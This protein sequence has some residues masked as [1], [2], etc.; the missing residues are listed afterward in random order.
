MSSGNGRTTTI[1]VALVEDEAFVREA[2]AAMLDR[3]PG[4]VTVGTAVSGEEAVELAVRT[5]PDVMMVDIRIPGMAPLIDGIEVIRALGRCAPTVRCLV[6]TTLGTPGELRRAMAAGARGFL[7]KD[8]RPTQVLAAVQDVATGGY[9][10]SPALAAAVLRSG[11]SPLT[12][13]ELDVLR[14][15]RSHGSVRSIATQLHLAEGTVRN[16][17]STAIGKMGASSRGE[18]ART[19]EEQGWL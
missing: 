1:R 14:L 6:F 7:V 12:A 16:Y 15:S 19:A 3:M 9:A 17:L 5:V 8:T 2:F 11:P 13:R 10:L 18:A 4:I